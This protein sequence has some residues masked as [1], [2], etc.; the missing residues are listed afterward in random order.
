MVSK[1]ERQVEVERSVNRDLLQRKS[2]T[3]Y[4]LMEALAQ[5]PASA[6]TPVRVSA[7]AASTSRSRSASLR[8]SS[9]SEHGRH[10]AGMHVQARPQAARA[11]LAAGASSTLHSNAAAPSPASV[12]SSQRWHGANEHAPWPVSGRSS[13]QPAEC[14]SQSIH[15]AEAAAAV[16]VQAADSADAHS[17]EHSG[18]GR[19]QHSPTPSISSPGALSHAAHVTTSSERHATT[20]SSLLVAKYARPSESPLHSQLR[21]SMH[22]EKGAANWQDALSDG[23]TRV[24]AGHLPHGH[25]PKS[26]TKQIVHDTMLQHVASDKASSRGVYSLV[27]P[28]AVAD[29]A[30]HPVP[31]AQLTVHIDAKQGVD[32]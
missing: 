18:I 19:P 9:A 20:H 6:T 16:D 5:L 15:I 10:S 28:A 2:D 11:S 23:S 26:Y 13:A 25:S 31:E 8:H 14:H 24:A 27:A 3:E 4:Q 32:T 1:L 12:R 30:Q 17:G 7:A 22:S 21:C 29:A